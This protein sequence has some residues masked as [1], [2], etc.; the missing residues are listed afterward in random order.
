M[1]IF[2][3]WLKGEAHTKTDRLPKT[4]GPSPANINQRDPI[5]NT[6]RKLLVVDDNPVILKAF[7]LKFR[8]LGFVVLTANDGSSAVAAA[9]NEHPDL[10]ILDINF[11]PD[12]GSS[13]LQWN[14]FSIMQWLER[15]QDVASIPVIIITS[16]DPAEFK[17]KALTAGAIAFFQKPIDHQ[18]LLFTIYR[19]IGSAGTKPSCG[20]AV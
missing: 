18:E 19:A 17:E 14:G 8:A 15:F 5:A 11:P 10:I 12:V 9:R 20:Q 4:A 16:D 3:K 13:G 1:K 6:A 2:K 7:E